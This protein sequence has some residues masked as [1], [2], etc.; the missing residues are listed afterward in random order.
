MDNCKRIKVTRL[1]EGPI[2]YPELDA[3]IGTNING[4]SLIRVPD[5]VPRPLGRYY[6]Y[7]ADHKGHYIRLAYSDHLIGPWQIHR[8][9]TLQL[10]DTPYLQTAAEIPQDFDTTKLARP[11]GPG[12]PSP[13][14]DMTLPHIASPDITVDH[15]RRQIRMY[16]HGLDAFGLQP[17]RVAISADGLDFI[18]SSNIL[19]RP[20][21]RAFS[22]AGQLYTLSMPGIFYRSDDGLSQFEQG[23]NLFNPNMR[24]CA[25]LVRGEELLVFWTQVGDCPERIYLSSIPLLADWWHWRASEPQELLRPERSWEGANQPLQASQRSS[26]STLV[27]QLRDPTIFVEHDATYLLYVV[28]GEAGI[29][30]ARL[31]FVD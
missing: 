23:P 9:G 21:M 8:G 12:M 2:I 29:A 6:L 30:I 1:L 26:V 10:S 5:W 27:N 15:E 18:A 14:D 25:V 17:S 24:H 31:D 16:Y 4:P 7:F 22:F 11:R 28:G 20:Y 19:G 13:L 3:S